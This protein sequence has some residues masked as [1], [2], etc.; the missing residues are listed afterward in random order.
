MDN[1]NERVMNNIAFTNIDIEHMSMIDNVSYIN[2]NDILCDFF[3]LYFFQRD[4]NS[5][6]NRKCLHVSVRDDIKISH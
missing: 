1:D 3:H 2:S 4:L 5:S 6:L